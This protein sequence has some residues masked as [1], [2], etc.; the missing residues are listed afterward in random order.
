M[1]N[2]A[3]DK[4]IWRFSGA[5]PYLVG[6][7]GA[8]SKH[9]FRLIGISFLIII[10]ITF[11][12]MAFGMIKIFDSIL[13]PVIVAAVLTFLMVTIYRL[14]I[15]SLEPVALP[16]ESLKGSKKAANIIRISVIVL[17]GFFVSKQFEFLCFNWLVPEEE[18]FNLKLKS[19]YLDQ[20][21]YMYMARMIKLNTSLNTAFVWLITPI[22]LGLF[23]Y[24]TQVKFKLIRNEME[25]YRIKSIVERRI[26]E[27]DY[28]RFKLAYKSSFTRQNI[29]N[30]E[31]KD[32]TYLDP[33]FNTKRKRREAITKTES[34]FLNLFR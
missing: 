21:D 17:F 25:Y 28:A 31:F 11:L 5:D 32:S 22:V 4:L 13:M 33:P 34:D 1:V 29:S 6:H 10:S 7:S 15:L 30:V 26:V 9:R 12:P 2:S 3:I 18:L 24:P 16:V 19:L 8:D 14:N 27:Q 20:T 23:L